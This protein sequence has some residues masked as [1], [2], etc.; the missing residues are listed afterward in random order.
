MP[1]DLERPTV[2]DNARSAVDRPHDAGSGGLDP[3]ELIPVGVALDHER[4]VEPELRFEHSDIGSGALQE[5]DHEPGRVIELTALVELEVD[6]SGFLGSNGRRGD[7]SGGFRC[8]IHA[9][10]SSPPH[11][12]RHRPEA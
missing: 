2:G 10:F 8:Y 9:R 5:V 6:D 12:G 1:H 7:R 11:G 4:L 3:D